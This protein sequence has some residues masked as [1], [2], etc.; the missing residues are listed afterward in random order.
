MS[1]TKA[2]AL[3]TK[4][5]LSRAIQAVHGKFENALVA[6]W[7]IRGDAAKIRN[8]MMPLRNRGVS[9]AKNRLRA[10]VTFASARQGQNLSVAFRTRGMLCS[11]FFGNGVKASQFRYRWQNSSRR[12]LGSAGPMFHAL[13]LKFVSDRIA[14]YAMHG[15]GAMVLVNVMRIP[16]FGRRMTIGRASIIW[17]GA[18]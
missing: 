17:P 7:D 8:S 14:S 4:K 9:N 2:Q 1:R 5:I 11:N 18:N 16:C 10:S 15:A 6:E 13:Q 12:S 3:T